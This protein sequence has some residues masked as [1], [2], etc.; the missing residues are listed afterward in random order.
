MSVRLRFQHRCLEAAR[1]TERRGAET[2]T[3]AEGG[4]KTSAD[5]LNMISRCVDSHGK[6][7]VGNIRMSLFLTSARPVTSSAHPSTPG[8]P[9]GSILSDSPF[10]IPLFFSSIIP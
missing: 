4:A 8:Q 9:S 3:V 6:I 5:K 2:R 1:W 10:C 7:N